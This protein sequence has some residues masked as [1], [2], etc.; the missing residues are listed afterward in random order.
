MIQWLTRDWG[1]KLISLILAIGLWYYAVGEESIEVTRTVPLE[2]TIVNPQMSILSTS[3]QMVQVTLSAPRTLLSDIAS[4][5]IRATHEIGSE[6]KEAGDYSFRL[7][8]REIKLPSPQIRVAK[9]EP[10][11]VRVTLDQ[12]IVKKL[13]IKPN[14]VGEP[15]FGYKLS[16]KEIQ[17]DPN[18]I[19]I[20]GP[21][22]AL[23]K[24]DSIKTE[25]IDLVG[26][27][28]SFRR[29]VELDLPP[30]IK[31]L[32]ESLVDVYIPIKEEFDEKQF[33]D[34]PVRVLGPADVNVRT[35]VEPPVISFML[36]G[37]RR[38]L[39]KLAAENIVAY[40]DVTKLDSGQH[41]LPVKI[42][43]P[44]DISLKESAPTIV[45][46]SIKK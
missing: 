21:K 18:A 8:P 19:L 1:I 23:E 26:R 30:N 38:Q 40:L 35:T 20:E 10:E 25:M 45:K 44:E 11:V 27:I 22:G 4:R 16:E 37:S 32:S 28:R 34:I 43:L 24:L 3:V 5:E 2:I 15:A 46:V 39:E 12:L 36:K 13:E 31:P 33:Q 29:T 42:V 14:L 9:I 6:A 41:E 17:L 7:E